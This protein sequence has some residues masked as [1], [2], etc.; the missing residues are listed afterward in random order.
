MSLS[1]NGTGMR[2]R[3]EPTQVSFDEIPMLIGRAF[4]SE[5]FSVQAEETGRFEELTYF[6]PLQEDET[7]AEVLDGL[8]EGFHSL[9]L[10]D[11]LF[12][13]HLRFDRR[14]CY[15]LNY[16]VDRVRFPAQLTVDR[17]LVFGMRVSDVSPRNEAWIVTSEVE[18]GEYGVAKP[19]L[20]A[21]WKLF[22][23]RRGETLAMP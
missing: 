20:V 22:V 11:A 19:G 7:S 2:V 14:E 5:P 16:G 23:A 21:S 8:I 15:V 4:R 3:P 10:I 6:R 12:N 17:E 9:S 1:L 13:E 18:L